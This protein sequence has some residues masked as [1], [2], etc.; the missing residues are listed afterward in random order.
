MAG[1]SKYATTA[2]EHA[3]IA[4]KWLPPKPCSVAKD[5]SVFIASSP[6][7]RTSTNVRK[8]SRSS[9]SALFISTSLF[10]GDDQNPTT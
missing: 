9:I 4:L 10:R 7:A 1:Q 3:P 2:R 8:P 6:V 5:A